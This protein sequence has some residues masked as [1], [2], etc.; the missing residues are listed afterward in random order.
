MD[1]ERKHLIWKRIGQRVRTLRRSQ[2]MS[3]DALA[4][5]VDV[6][7]NQIVRLEAGLGGTTVPRLVA[8]ASALGVHIEDL[9]GGVADEAT[10]ERQSIIGFRG[11]G[12]TPDEAEKVLDYIEFLEHKREKR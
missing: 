11:H 4:V 6:A 3:V 9:V 8:I 1:D 7:R 2:K 5:A 12:L 10:S